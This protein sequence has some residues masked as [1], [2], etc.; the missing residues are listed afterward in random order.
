MRLNKKDK[1]ELKVKKLIDKSE[2][3][4][5]DQI[6]KLKWFKQGQVT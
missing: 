1:N 2:L 3:R 6:K 5:K 4:G